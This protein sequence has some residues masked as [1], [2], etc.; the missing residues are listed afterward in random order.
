MGIWL[1]RT[2][3]YFCRPPSW[4][5]SITPA[6]SKFVRHGIS[7]TNCPQ[8]QIITRMSTNASLNLKIVSW[9]DHLSF[10]LDVPVQTVKS[11]IYLQKL[12]VSTKLED[13]DK[14]LRRTFIS[15]HL[16]HE[17]ETSFGCLEGLWQTLIV[18]ISLHWLQQPTSCLRCITVQEH[19]LSKS[20]RSVDISSVVKLQ[21]A[22]SGRIWHELWQRICSHFY[23]LC[24]NNINYW[25]SE[26][27]LSA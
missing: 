25:I 17:E 19:K 4:T 5:F 7:D 1:L 15:T 24:L 2:S 23:L 12:K 18:S 16:Y 26:L 8:C 27:N 13:F 20:T 11:V 21:R 14:H 6:R 3:G 9:L 22:P 10:V